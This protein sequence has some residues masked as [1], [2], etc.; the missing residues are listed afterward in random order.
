MIGA[1]CVVDLSHHN[2]QP[3][4]QEAKV[5]GIVGV[6]QK[7][8]QGTSFTDPTFVTNRQKAMDAQVLFGAYHFGVGADGVDQADFFLK[9]VQPAPNELV[10]LDFEANPQGPSMSLEEARAF[11]THVN[12]VCGRWPGLYSG[13]YLKE[14]LGATND[15][16]LTNCWLWIS[17]YGPTAVIP[18]A[19]KWWTMWQYTDG[20]AGLEPLPVDGIGACDR[21]TYNGAIED[22]IAFWQGGGVARLSAVT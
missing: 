10:V 16:V 2:G 15:P 4:L 7:A 5:A 11:V 21:D 17:Q 8:T 19:W 13:H 12:A 6:I 3:D 14:L 20:A 1:N 9:T 18:P 22:L